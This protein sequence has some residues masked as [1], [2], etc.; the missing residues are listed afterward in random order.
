MRYGDP[1]TCVA[2]AVIRAC[3]K[4]LPDIEYDD[5]YWD[6]K[7]NKQYVKRKR[8]PEERDVEVAMYLQYFS[9]TSLG[10]GGLAAQGAS[11]TYTTAVM[12][13]G[14]AAVYRGARLDYLAKVDINFK[15]L[16]RDQNLPEYLQA[17][18]SELT[19][20]YK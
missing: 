7:K 18:T 17:S 13:Q 9:D 10:R 2:N 3:V 19:V 15:K 14:I 4:D 6:E 16:L 1:I 12:S 5:F 8:R 11:E 20:T